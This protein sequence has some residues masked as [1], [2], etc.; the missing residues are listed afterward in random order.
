MEP[1]VTTA[2]PSLIK[3]IANQP[4]SLSPL[5]NLPVPTPVKPLLISPPVPIPPSI[6]ILTR[7]R[8]LR[9]RTTNNRAVTRTRNVYQTNCT[10]F[11]A[12][13]FQQRRHQALVAL[14]PES[15]QLREYT[16]LRK[17]TESQL[18]LRAA[19]NEIERLSNGGENVTNRS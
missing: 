11:R 8:S 2:S 6:S 5:L 18:W 3:P 12:L 7:T 13:A 9:Q 14:D 4:L 16:K 19:T 1:V 15:Q 10:K 17:G